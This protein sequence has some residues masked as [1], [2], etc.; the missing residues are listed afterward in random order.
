M[1]IVWIGCLFSLSSFPSDLTS[2]VAH[3]SS[4]RTIICCPLHSICFHRLHGYY[5]T[6]RLLTDH[7]NFSAL[8]VLQFSYLNLGIR[9]TS[10]VCIRYLVYSPRP[11]TPTESAVSRLTNLLML[12]AATM[13]ASTSAN[14]TLRGSIASRFRIAALILHCLRLNLT[15]RLRLQGCVLTACYALSGQDFHST[16]SYAP[17]W[18]TIVTMLPYK[19]NDS[20]S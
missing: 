13:T 9:Q 11:R 18:R 7:R 17:N 16:I 3:V 5:E 1:H 6:V 20:K 14:H 15:S 12:S 4:L 10:Q 19:F 8:Y 2:C